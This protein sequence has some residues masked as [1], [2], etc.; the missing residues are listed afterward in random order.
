MTNIPF[1]KV[2][3]SPFYLLC[4]FLILVFCAGGSARSDVASLVV[5]RPAAAIVLGIGLL[6]LEW[7]HVTAHRA[8]FALLAATVILVVVH[9]VPL[10]FGLWSEL[11]GRNLLVEID[12]AS[13]VGQVWRPLSMAPSQTENALFSLLVPAAVLVVASQLSED[14]LFKLLP[15]VLALAMLS[16]LIGVLQAIGGGS[17][18]YFYRVTNL[19]SAVGL[20]A[21]RNHQ[22]LLLAILFPM[23]AAFASTRSLTAES[24]RLKQWVAFALSLVLVPL[25]L[26]TGSRAGIALGVVAFVL[27]AFVYRPQGGAA[28]NRRRTKR[29][30]QVFLL[31]AFSLLCVVAVAIGVS[32][33]EAIDRLVAPDRSEADRL[34][35]WPVIW[36]IA[37]EYFPTGSGIGSFVEVYQISEPDKLLRPQYLNHAHNDGL[38]LILTGGLPAML[39]IVAGIVAF[40]LLVKQLL[41]SEGL[42]GRSRSIGLLGAAI[43]LLMLLSSAVDYPLRT[44]I[45]LTL[46]V[47]AAV[48]VSNAALQ[49][50]RLGMGFA[51]PEK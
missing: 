14:D 9:L 8:W 31:I 44:P 5:L 10:P 1:R 12:Q 36:Q 4:G 7:R 47:V 24:A 48:W 39:L 23:L 42:R 15:V 18:F 21:N 28:P 40:T 41:W 46:F 37:K 17:S 3:L 19:G 16:G 6:T 30:W 50:R 22:A 45:A 2:K 43:V 13:G 11:P 32:R 49:A 38:E 26:I 27:A 34:E 35:F 33:S 25:L 29:Q 51:G 20:F